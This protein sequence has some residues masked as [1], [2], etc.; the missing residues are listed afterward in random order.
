MNMT[1]L[2][3]EELVKDTGLLR[4]LLIEY[5]KPEGIRDE[6]QKQRLYDFFDWGWI[7]DVQNEWTEYWYILGLIDTHSHGN[8][9]AERYLRKFMH[10]ERNNDVDFIRRL[11]NTMS[12]F[13]T[14]VTGIPEPKSPKELLRL[15]YQEEDRIAQ[16]RQRPPPRKKGQRKKKNNAPKGG[17]GGKRVK[18]RDIDSSA[19][20]YKLYKER[21]K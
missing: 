5:M 19:K 17:G 6:E 18:Q 8:K 1:Q 7:H 2:T 3:R 10:R 20:A 13:V 12:Q 4:K 15:K 14:L 21:K 11:N 16:S 9:E